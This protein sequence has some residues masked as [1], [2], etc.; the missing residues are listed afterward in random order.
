[1]NQWVPQTNIR[2]P[3]GFQ[4]PP[5]P[6]IRFKGTVPTYADLPTDAAQGDMWNTDDTGHSYTWS[7]GAWIDGGSV[8]GADGLPGPPNVLDIGAVITVA[9]GGAAS[10]TIT[11]STPAQTLNLGIPRGDVGAQGIQGD[12]GLQGIPGPQGV[13]G[14]KGDKGDPGAPGVAT[15][16]S[17]APAS[18]VHGQMWWNPTT[19]TLS[20]RNGSAWDVVEATWG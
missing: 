10:A 17:A 15:V 5:G 9:P 8:R 3:Q 18:P 14:D 4:G 16:A 6:G 13:K 7:E 20:I 12:T 1:M 2:G 19:K 11:G